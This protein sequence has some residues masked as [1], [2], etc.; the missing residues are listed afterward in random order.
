MP[1]RLRKVVL[2]I[3]V[4]TTVGWLGAVLVFLVLALIGLT[5]QQPE[6]V[7]AVLA[8]MEPTAWYVLV[9]LSVASLVVGVVQSLGTPWGLVRHWWVLFKLVITTLATIV[10]LSYMAT[11]G[12][13]TAVATDRTASVGELRP[14][15]GSV[16]LHASLA[17]LGLL[18]TLVLSIYKPR[19]MTRYGQR[20][21]A[22]SNP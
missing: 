18:L 17:L 2:T 4:A 8:V 15:A 20:K 11:F 9:P 21:M 3:H 12:D 22:R 19:A 7:R 10:L 1:P 14:F 5:S 6:T 16:L 13:M